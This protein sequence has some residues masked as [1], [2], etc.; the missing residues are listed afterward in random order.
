MISRSVEKLSKRRPGP[1]T[2]AQTTIIIFN[3]DHKI[4]RNEKEMRK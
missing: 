4:M 1:T 2:Q 3:A